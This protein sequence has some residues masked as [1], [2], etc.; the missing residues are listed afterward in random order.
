MAHPA[1]RGSFGGF[2]YQTLLGVGVAVVLAR[3][4]A[5]FAARTFLE[6]TRLF[7]LVEEVV[8]DGLNFDDLRAMLAFCEQGA[9]PP[10]VQVHLLGVCEG[11]VLKVAELAFGGG[12]L[13]FSL[14]RSRLLFLKPL[15]MLSASNPGCLI[16]PA[17]NVCKALLEQV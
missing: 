8:V 17:V 2:A 1:A 12:G 7:A 10:E 14:F 3:V 15:L 6:V 4:D 11:G 9:V 16:L 13:L 5:F